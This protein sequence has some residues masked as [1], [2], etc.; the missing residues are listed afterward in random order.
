MPIQVLFFGQLFDITGQHESIV[1]GIEDTESL[2]QFLN[3][4]YPD[5][6]NC[7]C[8]IAVDKKIIMENTLLN[9]NSMV[10][11]MPPFSGG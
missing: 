7:K 10:A 9:E 2:I 8:I 11:L 5:L 4:K 6:K 1:E 3:A